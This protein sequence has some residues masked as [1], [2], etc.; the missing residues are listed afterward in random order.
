MNLPLHPLFVHV[1][2]ALA[3]LLPLLSG[4]LLVA[5]VRSWL[6]R[7]AWAL[8][9]T[10]QLVLVLS[11]VVAMRTGE[12]D[13][14]RIER[15]VPEAAIERHEEA[16]ETFVWAAG[17][18]LLL[19]MLPLMLRQR[20]FQVLGAAATLAGTLAVA[21]LGYQVGHAGGEIVYRHAAGDV[22]GVSQVGVAPARG[23]HDDDHR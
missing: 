7:R 12:A 6:P 11:S 3:V 15:V 17:G 13:E 23:D 16:A 5:L 2:I 21:G 22:F 19:S 20:R 9:A 10:G 18:V 1:P 4:A 8:V 14:D